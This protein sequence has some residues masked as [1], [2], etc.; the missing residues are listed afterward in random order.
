VLGLEP[1][2][3][4]DWSQTEYKEQLAAGYAKITPAFGLRAYVKDFNKLA[5]APKK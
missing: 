4:L 2:D 1:A 5:H 3:H